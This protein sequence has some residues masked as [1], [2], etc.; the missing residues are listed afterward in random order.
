MRGPGVMQGYW[1]RSE[2]TAMALRDGWLFIGDGAWM[3]ETG[4]IHVVDR[5]KD[6]IITGGENVYSDEVEAV[7]MQHP[8]VAQCAVIGVPSSQ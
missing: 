1:N 6:M 5:I 3:D 7:L 2:E 4:C 8:G